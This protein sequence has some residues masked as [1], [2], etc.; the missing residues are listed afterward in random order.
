MI[1]TLWIMSIFYFLKDCISKYRLNDPT[2]KTVFDHYFLDFKYYLQ[3]NASAEDFAP[4]LNIKIE[5]LD[6]I[7]ISYYGLSFIE[8]INEYRYKH[9]M[10]EMKNPFNENLTI[11]S[12][13][14]LSGFDN[15]ESFATYVKEKQ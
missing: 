7:S 3:K 15:N 9:F 8:L 1:Q 10:Q 2:S 4:I 5:S 6:K 11:E 13:I 14:K 12:L